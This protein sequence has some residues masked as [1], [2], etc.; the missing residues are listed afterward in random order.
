MYLR[1]NFHTKDNCICGKCG[2]RSFCCEVKMSDN[3]DTPVSSSHFP[4]ST[5][6]DFN[7]SSD[8]DVYPLVSFDVNVSSSFLAPI[9][10]VC[11]VEDMPS[12]LNQVQGRSFKTIINCLKE[13]FVAP[14][15]S[16]ELRSLDYNKIKFQ[17]VSFMLITFNDDIIFEL[18]PICFPIGHFGQI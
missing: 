3:E 10:N 7:N 6:I 5:F 2:F 11:H 14:H 18:L 9:L 1:H 8:E 15:S 4:S 12:N 17:Y 16:N 13:M